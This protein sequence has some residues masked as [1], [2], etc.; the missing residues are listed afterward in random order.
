MSIYVFFGVEN[1]IVSI[2]GLVM[3]MTILERN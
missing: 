3:Y 1:M 2:A